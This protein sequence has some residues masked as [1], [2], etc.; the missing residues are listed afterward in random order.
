LLD[1][2]FYSH[3]QSTLIQQWQPALGEKSRNMRNSGMMFLVLS[4]RVP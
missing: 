3:D 1:H 4:I 2:R